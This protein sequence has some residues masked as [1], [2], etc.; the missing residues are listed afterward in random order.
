MLD[1]RDIELFAG[2]HVT[3]DDARK[4]PCPRARPNNRV[5]SLGGSHL[6]AYPSNPSRHFRQRQLLRAQRSRVTVSFLIATA[7]DPSPA[8]TEDRAV[9]ELS[10][11]TFSEIAYELARRRDDHFPPPWPSEYQDVLIALHHLQTTLKM[12]AQTDAAAKRDRDNERK[13][14]QRQSQI[15]PR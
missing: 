4:L 3:L 14:M 13:F 1:A 15:P 11:A 7:G 6:Q 2:F 9:T 8:D 12:R 10:E 5:R